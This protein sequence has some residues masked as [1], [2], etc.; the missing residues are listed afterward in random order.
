LVDLCVEDVGLCVQGLVLAGE[1]GVHVAKVDNLTLGVG[2][3]KR[4]A[5]LVGPGLV[6]LVGGF[7]A[8]RLEL[9][10]AVGEILN[11]GSEVVIL[12]LKVADSTGEAGDFALESIN[13][14]GELGVL[15][16]EVL[17]GLGHHVDLVGEVTSG[18]LSVGESSLELGVGVAHGGD[19]VGQLGVG[20]LE[21]VNSVL[22]ILQLLTQHVNLI[23][24]IVVI[25]SEGGNVVLEGVVLGHNLAVHHVLLIHNIVQQAV[26][27]QT[28]VQV[29]GVSEISDWKRHC[30]TRFL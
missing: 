21:A 13:T 1:L 18:G 27:Q 5:L 12:H 7:S 10:V 2:Q 23:L 8:L 28:V 11:L 24:Q 29:V 14:L 20:R 26:V 22:E 17:V 9:H 6:E 15:S 4:E 19:V 25:V 30:E 16:L 3:G